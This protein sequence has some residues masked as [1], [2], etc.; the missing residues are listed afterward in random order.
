MI[1]MESEYPVFIIPSG[2]KTPVATKSELTDSEKVLI[3]TDTVYV[4]FDL[5]LTHLVLQLPLEI[6]EL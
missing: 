1:V 6:L 2:V 5:I 3:R 4:S